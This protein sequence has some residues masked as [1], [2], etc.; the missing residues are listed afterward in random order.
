MDFLQQIRWRPTIGDPSVMGWLTVLAYGLAALTAWLAAR[1]AARAP[2]MARGSSGLWLLVALLMTGLCLNKQLDLQS[3]FTAIGRAIAWKQGWYED[4]REFQKI[5]VIAVLGASALGTG[6]LA[7]LF[8]DF[9]KR[10]LLLAAGLVSLLTFI[11][12]RAISFHHVDVFLGQ[13]VSGMKMNWVL[14]LTGI[15]LVW[16]A[17]LREWRWPSRPSKKF[18]R[19]SP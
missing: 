1:R 13:R 12:V 4:R 19:T 5:F 2:G 18:R 15:G 8:R 9:W 10:H 17:A 6:L 16:L 11:V 7:L 14:E 3:L